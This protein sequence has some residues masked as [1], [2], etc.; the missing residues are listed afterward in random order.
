MRQ[1]TQINKYI[2]GLQSIHIALYFYG[3]VGKYYLFK[4]LIYIMHDMYMSLG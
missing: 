2:C 4:Q 1:C 3:R